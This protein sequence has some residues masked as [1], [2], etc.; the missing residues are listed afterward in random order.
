MAIYQE[1]LSMSIATITAHSIQ[2]SL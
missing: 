2:S 1:E